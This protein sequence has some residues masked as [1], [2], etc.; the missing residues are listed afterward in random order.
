MNARYRSQVGA[1]RFPVECFFAD[2]LADGTCDRWLP[3]RLAPRAEGTA[4][5]CKQ[6]SAPRRPGDD[7]DL[8]PWEVKRREER[9]RKL[10]AKSG[11][12]GGSADTVKLR[13][14]GY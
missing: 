9:A 3:M 6:L 2:D 14:F 4:A 5:T 12:K 10:A 8:A 13:V 7:R 1:K 11:E